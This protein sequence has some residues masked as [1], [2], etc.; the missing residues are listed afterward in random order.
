VVQSTYLFCGCG[1]LGF[2]INIEEFK[3]GKGS[4][5]S[6]FLPNGLAISEN[7]ITKSFFL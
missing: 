3:L 6:I 7:G 1:H 2:P 4:L 5:K